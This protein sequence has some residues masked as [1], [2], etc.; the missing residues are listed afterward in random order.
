MN[1]DDTTPENWLL[2]DHFDQ[3]SEEQR[4]ELAE[5]LR[6][7]PELSAKYHRL[8]G[9][10]EPLDAWTAPPA[11]SGIVDRILDRIAAE[12]QRDAP[13]AMIPPGADGNFS[14]NPS[15][16]L[17]ELIAIAAVIAFFAGI[18]VPSLSHV[19]EKSR[20]IACGN[21]LGAI[22]RAISAYGLDNDGALPYTQT[23]SGGSWLRLASVNQPYAPN[24]RNLFVLLRFRYVGNPESF[25]CPSRKD[26]V[27]LN[28][29]NPY[30]QADFSDPNNC[31]YD[32]LNMAGTTPRIGAAASLPY[33][34]DA[35]PL[36]V[37]G[38]FRTVDA[39]LTNSSNH[40]NGAG[41]NVLC[42]DGTVDWCTSP[43]CG[44]RGDNIWQ[45]RS[46]RIYKGTEIQTSP[47]D[48]FL[49]P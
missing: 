10:L 32:S 23:I 6:R 17:R 41:Q 47:E 13:V 33:M 20:Q 16:S 38:R 37:G 44:H 3:L 12:E 15:F 27:P 31:S 28:V 22:G 34:A 48:T 8:Q 14:F 42:L 40:P 21:N 4:R 11:P 49:V 5:A 7:D 46:V 24:S 29:K 9:V 36:F 1:H 39:D 43:N 30:A 19:R 18:L 26:A 25:I 45:I 2:D 35:N